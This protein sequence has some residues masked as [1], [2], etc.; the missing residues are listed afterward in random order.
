MALPV[1]PGT[2]VS[3]PGGP[4][5]GRPLA[6]AVGMGV[7]RGA[8]VKVGLTTGVLSTAGV[9]VAAGGG[10]GV[11]GPRVGSGTGVGL[12]GKGA[13]GTRGSGNAG[14][15]AAAIIWLFFQFGPIGPPAVASG[16]G[17][18]MLL[19]TP[20]LPCSVTRVKTRSAMRLPMATAV[21]KTMAPKRSK[22]VKNLLDGS[23]TSEHR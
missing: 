22:T 15:V 23:S 20:L 14:S 11:R 18:T 16:L 17:V 3:G 12:V 6:P 7:G 8:T 10:G 1:G 2:G 4:P 5:G 21:I 9:G 13:G 19:G